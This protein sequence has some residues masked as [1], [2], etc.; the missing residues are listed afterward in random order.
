M[1]VP[2]GYSMHSSGYWLKTADLSGPYTFDGTNMTLGYP[3]TMITASSGNVAN[4]SAVATLAAAAGKTTYIS[5]FEITSGG[6]TA[7][8]L[9]A[10]TVAGLTGG[11]ATYTYGCVAGA[12]VA[13]SPLQ[14]T[15][16]PPLPASAVNT[17]I[18][19]TLP[20]LGAGNTNATVVAHGYQQ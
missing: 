3:N 9:V 8:S 14:V 17:A 12:T 13:N 6:A 5:G 7:A 2:A 19:V 16:Y 11:T 15:F 18:V 20:A 4:A 1:A 10:A